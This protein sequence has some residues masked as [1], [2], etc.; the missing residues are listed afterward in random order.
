MELPTEYRSLPFFDYTQN[1]NQK[2]ESK[3]DNSKK[4]QDYFKKL[5][6]EEYSP[7]CVIINEKYEIIYLIGK[8]NYFMTLPKGVPN[9]ELFSVARAEFRQILNQAL[10]EVSKTKQIFYKEKIRFKWENKYYSVDLV[11]RPIKETS[12]SDNLIILIIF[13]NLTLLN[14]EIS[15]ELTTN[16]DTN[17]YTQN[18]ELELKTTRENLQVTIEELETANEELKSSNEE[19]QSINEELHS[20][21]EELKTS[22]EELQATNEELITV[23]AELRL[24]IDQLSNTN[25][26]INNLL[27]STDIGTIFLDNNLCI[28]RFTPSIKKIF[29]LIQTDIGRPFSDITTSIKYDN[30]YEDAKLV[31]ENLIRKEI[32]IKSKNGNSYNM[33]ITPYRTID[34]IIDGVVIIFVDI[35]Q[36]INKDV[37]KI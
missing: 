27:A 12:I 28:K 9:F 5:I 22:K 15:L 26:D 8:T 13:M 24:K 34:N 4:M 19:A 18:L 1:T 7:P 16:K 21:N 6:I 20:S 10:R 31:L 33:I 30:I 3:I 14:E 37:N 17:P 32:V 35:A 11:V 25:N 29:N 23:N 2:I 36:F